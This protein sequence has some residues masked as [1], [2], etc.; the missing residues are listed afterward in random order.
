MLNIQ[1][2]IHEKSVID[3]INSARLL[4]IRFILCKFSVRLFKNIIK[5]RS[6]VTKCAS[7]RAP[8][9][10][11]FTKAS[12]FSVLKDQNGNTR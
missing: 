6:V 5:A 11:S 12:V 2:Y 3:K 8:D 10:E 4:I 1:I 7:V 9:R